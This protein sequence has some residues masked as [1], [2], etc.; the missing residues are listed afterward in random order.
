MNRLNAIVAAGVLA[1]AAYAPQASAVVIDLNPGVPSFFAG[2]PG[3]G[4]SV[5]LS[6]NQ[7]IEVTSLGIFG[8]LVAQSFDVVIYNGDGVDQAPGSIVAQASAVSGGGGLM[9]NDI[10]V[11]ATL[12][13]A[14]DYIVHWRPSVSNSSWTSN[15]EYYPW[16]N[17]PLDDVDLGPLVMRDG[18]EGF[19][20]NSFTNTV[21]PHLRLNGATA[22]VPEPGS[23]ALLGFGLMALFALRRRS[24]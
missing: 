1:F 2:G 6:T 24:R 8:D 15:L 13:A 11:S 7:Q 5:Y 21:A 10:S 19:G 18:R 4:R 23:L 17:D 14:T 9:W 3:T 20:S 16:G 12:L 22:S